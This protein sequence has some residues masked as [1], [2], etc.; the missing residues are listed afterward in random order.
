MEQAKN[1][2]VARAVARG[3]EGLVVTRDMVHKEMSR[4]AVELMI[5]KV[6]KDS[7]TNPR[8]Q[9]YDNNSCTW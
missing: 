7:T 6:N 3:E 4:R 9:D 8:R 5:G 2:V 1:T